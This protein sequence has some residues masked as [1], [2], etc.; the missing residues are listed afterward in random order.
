MMVFEMDDKSPIG[1][2]NRVAFLGSTTHAPGREDK[3]ESKVVGLLQMISDLDLFNFNPTSAP[4]CS[5]LWMSRQISSAL[6]P[7]VPSSR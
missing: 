6:L 2:P 3:I 1:Q 7:K 5:T 4:A